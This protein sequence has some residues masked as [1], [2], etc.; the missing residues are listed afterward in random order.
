MIIEITGDQIG[1]TIGWQKTLTQVIANRSSLLLAPKIRI[2]VVLTFRPFAF[3][4][5]IEK[6][7]SNP[8]DFEL[9]FQQPPARPFGSIE[10][11]KGKLPVKADIREG[12]TGEDGQVPLLLFFRSGHPGGMVKGCPSGDIQILP[13]FIKKGTI[14]NLLNDQ[15]VRPDQVN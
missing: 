1:M 15:Y 4:V 13:K 12:N 2:G 3:E 8:I 9:R 7:P 14:S 5:K 6:I 11:L 10:I